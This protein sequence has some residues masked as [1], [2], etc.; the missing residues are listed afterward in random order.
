MLKPI[1]GL[2]LYFFVKVITDNLITSNL[3]CKSCGNQL[4]SLKYL[5]NKPSPL[6][7]KSWNTSIFHSKSKYTHSLNQS[8][9]HKENLA[10]IQL[11]ENPQGSHFELIT[12][13]KANV[14]FLNN[15]K[16]IADTWFPNFKWTI[17]LCPHCFIHI[18]WYFES[19]FDTNDFFFRILVKNLFDED[20]EDNLI[21][22]PKFKLY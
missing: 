11:L 22:E 20:Y 2:Y 17:C 1:L 19:I 9:Q 10:L 16:S 6:A 8:I 4:T 14:H 15:T 13:N 18:G 21:I 5:I 12:V 3:L 7:L